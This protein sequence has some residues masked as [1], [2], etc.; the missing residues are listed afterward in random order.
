VLADQQYGRPRRQNRE[1][2]G[3]QRGRARCGEQ[4]TDEP[5]SSAQPEKTYATDQRTTE[6]PIA[7]S[8]SQRVVTG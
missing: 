2:R 6:S 8:G 5:V 7:P 1:E 4:Q 3:G